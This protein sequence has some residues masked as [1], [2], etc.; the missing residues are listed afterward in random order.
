M[1]FL[2]PQVIVLLQCPLYGLGANHLKKETEE[3]ATGRRKYWGPG[4]SDRGKAVDD[5]RIE[6]ESV[7]LL[8]V[9]GL[10]EA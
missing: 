4:N 3:K 9:G 6:P 1:V 7:N 5:V 8:S 10:L 2:I